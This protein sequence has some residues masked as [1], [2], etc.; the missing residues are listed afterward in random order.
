[1]SIVPTWALAATPE[2][3]SA[4]LSSATPAPPPEFTPIAPRSTRGCGLVRSRS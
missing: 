1:M 2:S 3:G 4:M